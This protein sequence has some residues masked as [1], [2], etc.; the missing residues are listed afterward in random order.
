MARVKQVPQKSI[1]KPP[2]ARRVQRH[3]YR[4]GTVALREIRKYQRSVDLLIPKQSFQRLVREMLTS[5]SPSTNRLEAAALSALH[6]RK[7]I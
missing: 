3:R 6:V 1:G 4:Q 2:F 5:M 7:Y